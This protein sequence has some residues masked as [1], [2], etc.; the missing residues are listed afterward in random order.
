MNSITIKSI[1]NKTKRRDPWFL[2][3]YTINPYSGCSFNCT[4]CYIRGSKYGE[5]ME[6]K[7]AV[8]N[9]AIEVLEKQ[10]GNRAR[11][12]QYGIIVL[13]SATE[14]YL[15]IEKETGLT[16]RILEV[17]LDHRFPVHVITR[18]DLVVR[19]LDVLNKINKAAVLPPDLAAAHS[20]GVFITFSFS[21][22]DSQVA[23]VFEPGATDPTFR[24]QTLKHCVA[25][26]FHS[27]VSLM[28]LLPA[29][30]DSQE[31]LDS[32]FATFS[33]AGAK[34]VLPASLTLFGSGGSDAKS[35]TLRAVEKNFP[36]KLDEYKKLFAT[37]YQ[38]SQSYLLELNHRIRLAR[39]RYHVHDRIIYLN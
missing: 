7:L 9:N 17:I 1:L 4:F 22:L 35:L 14:P 10:L 13:S 30:S 18:S 15:Q 11:K 33:S 34:Y 32:F 2:D 23:R 25:E 5:H 36:D 39:K 6:D 31:S 29:I 20:P 24:L 19:D 21:S 28:P 27:G 26:G 37:G 16:R 8:K 3:D 38:P 12:G